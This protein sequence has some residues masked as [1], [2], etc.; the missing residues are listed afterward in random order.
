MNKKTRIALYLLFLLFLL[1]ALEGLLR[2]F[3]PDEAKGQQKTAGVDKPKQV[4][5]DT[6]RWLRTEVRFNE[7][8]VRGEVEL[9]KGDLLRV[10]FIGDSITFGQRIDNSQTLPA[11]FQARV[12]AQSRLDI[13]ALNFGQLGWNIKDLHDLFKSRGASFNP[14]L[15]I[16]GLCLNDIDTR[17]E[18]YSKFQKRKRRRQAN[19]AWWTR[20]KILSI[21]QRWNG[22][23][24]FD[25]YLEYLYLGDERAWP[26]FKKELSG[27]SKSVTKRGARFAVVV[28]P[29]FDKGHLSSSTR[30]RINERVVGFCKE[31]GI[32]VMDGYQWFSP[33]QVE[34][35]RQAADDPHP[36]AKAYKI[37]AARLHDRLALLRDRE[38][39]KKRNRWTD[40]VIKNSENLISN[41]GF[42]KTRVSGE[43]DRWRTPGDQAR[44]DWAQQVKGEAH[45]GQHALR[46]V[47]RQADQKL[48]SDRFSV[49]SGEELF[50]AFYARSK[51]HQRKFGL[52]TSGLKISAEY[53]DAAGALIRG[54]SDRFYFH[55]TFEA[56]YPYTL[57]G[58]HDWK[59]FAYGL[60]VPEAASK[61]NLVITSGKDRS[62]VLI[63][64][65]FA[66]VLN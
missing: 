38:F 15:V 27:F 6:Q 61:A 62:N 32:E 4:W 10:L 20:L 57:A 53:Y 43:L 44:G 25:D 13:E 7:Y 39:I 8:Q 24:S 48:R 29:W 66:T 65:I 2:V 36:N 46:C 3:L 49:A 41:P 52:D 47:S 1:G 21:L 22:G 45:G 60:P 19:P 35:Y 40:E 23:D 33:G 11:F 9:A 54:P 63:D 17:P 51:G 16:Y 59:L 12:K 64:D 18:D 30:G 55:T 26:A 31:Q 42:E 5:T 50:I 28:L 58:N 56:P 34:Q 14:E 37:M